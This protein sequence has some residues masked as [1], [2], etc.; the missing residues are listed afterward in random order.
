MVL[1]KA[2]E[3]REPDPIALIPLHDIYRRDV[4][5]T[6]LAFTFELLHVLNGKTIKNLQ[7]PSSRL[8][9]L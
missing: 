4:A 1:R 7:N 3:I 8:T 2:T 9:S 5:L 6:P